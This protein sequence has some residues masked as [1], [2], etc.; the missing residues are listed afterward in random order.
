M[1]K[2]RPLIR[3]Q[4][5]VC[6]LLRIPEAGPPARCELTFRN[7]NPSLTSGALPLSCF[8]GLLTA[9]TPQTTPLSCLWFTG[10]WVALSSC[11]SWVLASLGVL[12]TWSQIWTLV[13][14]YWK[15]I[16]FNKFEN[17]CLYASSDK[18]SC[19]VCL[20]SDLR[21]YRGWFRLRVMYLTPFSHLN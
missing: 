12:L 2:C 17:G 15:C 11:C 16:L 13:Y 9:L 1:M 20:H 19:S 6:D 18:S 14:F 7:Y 21:P 3:S 10:L 8:A 5:W 4:N